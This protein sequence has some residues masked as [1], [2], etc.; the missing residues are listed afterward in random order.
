MEAREG[1]KEWSSCDLGGGGG[2]VNYYGMV[3]RL[4][5]GNGG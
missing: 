5:V 2:E 3:L 1:G 4:V